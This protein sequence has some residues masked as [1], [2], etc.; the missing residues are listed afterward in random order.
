MD[1]FHVAHNGYGRSTA[2]RRIR[3]KL[4]RGRQVASISRTQ[5]LYDI[6]T[7]FAKAFD[8]HQVMV[9]HVF[10][11]ITALN[12]FGKLRNSRHTS[13]RNHDNIPR[14]SF[15][16]TVRVFSGHIDVEIAMSVMF[17]RG[18]IQTA[19]S[20]FGYNP[21]NQRR[22]AR[23]MP[24]HKSDCGAWS[25]K[26]SIALGA[27]AQTRCVFRAKRNPIHSFRARPQVRF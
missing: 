22:L 7:T 21:N 24:A 4:F 15:T 2:H 9:R 13:R 8:N 10:Y 14:P 16:M 27:L 25:T 5:D 3:A 12:L 11:D 20:K 23:I 18:N 19:R 26:A 6:E 17:Y 1:A